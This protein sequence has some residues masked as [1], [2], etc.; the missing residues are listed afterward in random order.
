MRI[1]IGADIMP[2]YDGAA[3]HD[4]TNHLEDGGSTQGCSFHHDLLDASIRQRNALAAPQN[5]T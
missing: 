3:G 4:H 5:V 1:A 2:E